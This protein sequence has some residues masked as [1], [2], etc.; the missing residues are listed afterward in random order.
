MPQASTQVPV[1]DRSTDVPV[2]PRVRDQLMAALDRDLAGD[3]PSGTAFSEDS[4]HAAPSGVSPRT[5]F[6]EIG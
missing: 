2:Q 3:A 6:S 5:A 4:P 1:A